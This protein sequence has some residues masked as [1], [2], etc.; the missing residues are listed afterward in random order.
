MSSKKTSKPAISLALRLTAAL[1]ITMGICL[2]I[3]LGV[4]Y[5]AILSAQQARIDEKLRHE[6]AEITSLVALNGFDNARG[7][8]LDAANAEGTGQILYRIT[9]TQGRVLIE[10]DTAEWPGIE[11]AAGPADAWTIQEPYFV[12]QEIA[13]GPEM[14]RMIFAPL[15]AGR[16]VQ[17][18]LRVSHELRPVEELRPVLLAGGLAGLVLSM[19]AGWTIAWRALAPLQTMTETALH[20]AAGNLDDRMRT[21]SRSLEL[22]R[23]TSAFNT[24]LDRVQSFIRELR[25]LNDGIAHDARTILARSHLAAERLLESRPLTGEQESLTVTIIENSSDLLG[26]LNTIMDLSE[27]NTGMAQTRFAPIE[28]N[29][30]AA[31]IVEFFEGAAKDNGIDIALHASSPAIVDGDRDRLRRALA[32]LLD[33]AIK[34]TGPGGR[35]AFEIQA[36]ADTVSISVSDTGAGIP[37]EA[38]DRI[39]ERFYRADTSRSGQGHG[40]GLSLV[41]AVARMHRGIVQVRSEVGQ[42]STFT[43]V[44][45]QHFKSDTPSSRTRRTI[46]SLG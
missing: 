46:G 36:E 35:I 3:T 40:L 41:A 38:Q 2:A 12:T 20:I 16:I 1:A 4:V 14:A 9:D 13:G 37:I 39:F 23:L 30:L 26:M 19:L 21:S 28:L 10:S 25:D 22:H 32:N 5:M 17:V 24:M 27:M 18:V 42:G 34:Y 44:L 6:A 43:L 8:L 15:E 31:D 29:E 33:N 45:P 7:A 11:A